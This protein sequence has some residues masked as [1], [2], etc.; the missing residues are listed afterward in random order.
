MAVQPITRQALLN[1][2]TNMIKNLPDDQLQQAWAQIDSWATMTAM[3]AQDRVVQR[4][5]NGEEVLEFDVTPQPTGAIHYLRLPIRMKKLPPNAVMEVDETYETASFTRHLH[6][7][8]EWWNR[9]Y[10]TLCKDASLHGQYVAVSNGELFSGAT[11]WEVYQK[12]REV[13]AEAVPYIFFLKSP[14]G[15]LTH[16]H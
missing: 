6:T 8:I 15:L 4:D 9:H 16:A 7:N 14:N 11:Y 10:A 13:Q 5:A 12:A 1:K 2:M 3:Q